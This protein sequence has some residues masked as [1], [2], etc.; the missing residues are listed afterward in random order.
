M[1][2][3][4]NIIMV[5]Y[6]LVSYSQILFRQIFFKRTFK[7]QMNAFLGVFRFIFVGG[8]ILILSIFFDAQYFYKNLFND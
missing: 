8:P 7:D 2:I 5:F 6:S 3:V 4:L 1:F